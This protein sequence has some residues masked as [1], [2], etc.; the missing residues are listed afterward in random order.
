MVKLHS[1]VRVSVLDVG[2]LSTFEEDDEFSG[3]AEVTNI[4][5]KVLNRFYDLTE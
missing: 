2:N 1:K 5:G 4:G 3:N